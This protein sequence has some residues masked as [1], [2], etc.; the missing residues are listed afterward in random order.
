MTYYLSFID[1]FVLWVKELQLLTDRATI[2]VECV[3]QNDKYL[4]ILVNIQH[5]TPDQ[6]QCDYN[7]QIF[8]ICLSLNLSI[9]SSQLVN[10]HM[11]HHK[12]LWG[13]KLYEVIC[14]HLHL[15]SSL[16]LHYKDMQRQ[17]LKREWFLTARGHLMPVQKKKN[18]IYVTWTHLD[19]ESTIW[20]L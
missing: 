8:V 11:Q 12:C 14:R 19:L 18:T 10:S 2:V 4:T 3:F 17:F 20:A 16:P 15:F 1:F 9:F 7:C 13:E 6:S 5:S